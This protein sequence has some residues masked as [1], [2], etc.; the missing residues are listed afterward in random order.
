MLACIREDR[1]HRDDAATRL[2]CRDQFHL[3]SLVMAAGH[4]VPAPAGPTILAAA[5]PPAP[6][7]HLYMRMSSH[8]HHPN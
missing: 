1:W 4:D 2:S 3:M 7:G 5:K 6:L 8:G